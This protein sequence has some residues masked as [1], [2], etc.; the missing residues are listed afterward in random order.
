[1]DLIIECLDV[2]GYLQLLLKFL[3]SV[4]VLVFGCKHAQRDSNALGI[5]RVNHR[6]VYLGGSSERR[7]GLR[8]Q[9]NNLTDVSR[10]FLQ[11]FLV[12]NYLSTPAHTQNS[13]LLNLRAVLSDR[14]YQLRHLLLSGWRVRRSLKKRAKLLSFF[15]GVWR[16]PA[17]I[18]SL[19][20]EEVGH[21]DLVLVVFVV[22]VGE[23]IG[24]LQGLRAVA[25]D[26][27]DDEDG[28]GGAG[29]ASCV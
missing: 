1:M 9:G 26:V 3:D 23:D 15:L 6:W 21:V 5:V 22:G 12:L 10:V 4:S 11:F 8:G 27:I 20:L 28:R 18:C 24:T 25:E 2:F 14:L 29:G 13:H 17:V 19:A 7:V 16:Y